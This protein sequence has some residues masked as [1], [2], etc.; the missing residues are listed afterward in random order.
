MSFPQIIYCA[1]TLTILLNIRIVDGG[2][3]LPW[4]NA[5]FYENTNFPDE[6]DG[7]DCGGPLFQN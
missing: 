4:N 1:G 2:M 6:V 5:A 7:F 3:K